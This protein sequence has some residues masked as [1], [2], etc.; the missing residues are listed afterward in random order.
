MDQKLTETVD[1]APLPLYPPPD[2]SVPPPT[3]QEPPRIPKKS[4][5]KTSSR[6][7][8]RHSRQSSRDRERSR[9]SPSSLKGP[10]ASSSRDY[11]SQ[12]RY[13]M[14]SRY[15]SSHRSPE[16][17]RD[18]Y[19]RKQSRSRSR[20]KASSRRSPNYKSSSTRKS[21][22]HRGRE[23]EAERS[24]RSVSHRHSPKR[25]SNN[26]R[27]NSKHATRRSS[28]D[29]QTERERLL[30]N[31]RKNYCETSEQ[32]SKKLLEMAHDEAQVSWIRSSPADIFYRRTNGNVV[33]STPRL[34]A[35]CTLFEDELLRRS[36]KIKAAQAPYSAPSRKR[37]IRACRHKCEI[38]LFLFIT[39]S[40]ARE[41]SC[42]S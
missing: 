15:S 41:E 6:D 12:S 7:S 35:L 27:D 38:I 33:E 17:S 19:K 21:P 32:I 2:F 28:N 37:K 34:D 36:E 10:R 5:S 31:W 1:K 40:K 42:K 26:T 23:R 8:S 14:T 20:S 29:P 4:E 25:E 3:I 24:S 30:V 9:Y 11:R 22:P 16:R 13:S 39:V 18:N